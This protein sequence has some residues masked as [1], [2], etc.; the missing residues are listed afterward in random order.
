[1]NG[2]SKNIR[3]MTQLKGNKKLCQQRHK[4]IITIFT[5][6]RDHFSK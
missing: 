2:K 6:R 4:N 1:M 3:K 5:F